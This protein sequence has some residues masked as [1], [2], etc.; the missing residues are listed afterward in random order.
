MKKARIL[1]CTL[2]KLVFDMIWNEVADDLAH[3]RDS[4]LM[5]FRLLG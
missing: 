5:E 3:R 1:S 4:I 2:G